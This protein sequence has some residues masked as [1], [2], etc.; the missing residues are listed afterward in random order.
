[1]GS[2]PR[3][4]PRRQRPRRHRRTQVRAADAD[5]HYIREGFTSGAGRRA[6][7]HGVREG[8]RALARRLDFPSH[9]NALHEERL[10]REIAQRHVH[11]GAALRIIDGL[12]GEQRGAPAFE[13]ARPGE[14]HQQPQ[15]L[16]SDLVLGEVEQQ[17][18]AFDGKLFKTQ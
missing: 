10:G 11:G 16:A 7:A 1:M 18:V 3:A 13:I 15:R 6:G 8:Q 14:V 2:R 12:A 17:T 9:I 4:A 5:I